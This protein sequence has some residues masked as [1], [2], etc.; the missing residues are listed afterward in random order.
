MNFRTITQ[1]KIEDCSCIRHLASRIWEPTY[2]N[3]LS[4]EQLAYMFEWMYSIPSLEN[5][6]KSGHVFF[7]AYDDGQPAGYMSI[8]K[9]HDNRYHLQKIYVLPSKQGKGLGSFLIK[10]AEK[11]LR[12]LHPEGVIVL[13]LNVNRNNKAFLFYEKSGFKIEREG[14]FDI[15][16]GFFMNDY[17]MVKELE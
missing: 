2:R 6:M 4:P 14:D 10:E 8:E 9:E 7:I 12:Q 13:A 5:Q 17:I 3:I 15:G 1:A 11:Y 16:N